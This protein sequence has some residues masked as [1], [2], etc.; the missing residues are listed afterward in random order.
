MLQHPLTV[1]L[2]RQASNELGK[3]VLSEDL[4]KVILGRGLG[5]VVQLN[6][7]KIMNCFV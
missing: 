4:N 1:H 7:W 5:E 3:R 2:D 6:G